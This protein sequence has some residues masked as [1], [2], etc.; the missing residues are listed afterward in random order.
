[1][2]VSEAMTAQ[3]VTAKPGDSVR[4][5]AKIMAEVDTGAVPVFEGGK[6][7]GLVTDRDIVLRVVAEGGDLNGPISGVMSDHVQSCRPDDSVADAAGKMASH[8]LRR[9]VVTDDSGALVGI[10]SLGDIATDYGAKKVGEVLEEIS[11]EAHA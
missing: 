3:V 6:V 4:S 1:M 2:K 8:Q 5:V 7:V 10:L 11:A 9:L